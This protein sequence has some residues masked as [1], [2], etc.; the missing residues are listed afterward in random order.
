[1]P[2]NTDPGNYPILYSFRRCPYAIR[3]RMVLLITGTAV[4]LREVWLKQKPASMLEAS[5]KGTVPVLIY[6][7]AEG[8]NVIEESL[9]IALWALNA[10]NSAELNWPRTDN[11]DNADN[12]NCGTQLGLIKRN[13]SDFKYWLDRYKYWTGY[14]QQS[15]SYYRAKAQPFLATL[16]QQLNR[17]HYLFGSSA[18]LAD[19]A[20][21]PFVRQFAS[22]DHEWFE[23]SDYPRI[24]TWL[25]GWIECETFKLCMK[26]QSSWQPGQEPVIL[27]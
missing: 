5:P 22:V 18:T 25:N 20:I 17:H 11:T 15:Q 12:T 21:F 19:V 7:N 16:E 9:D 6:K 27:K 24:R 8:T 2:D 14:P 3:A 4:E 10:S 1:M 23:Q 13:D 26:K